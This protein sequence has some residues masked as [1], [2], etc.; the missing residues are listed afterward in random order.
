MKKKN[1]GAHVNNES[2]TSTHF[3][4]QHFFLFSFGNAGF[5][6]DSKVPLSM[7]N[8]KVF[9]FLSFFFFQSYN[10]SWKLV[11]C[12]CDGPERINRRGN[13]LPLLSLRF[14]DNYRWTF[15]SLLEIPTSSTFPP[16][17]LARPGASSRWSHFAVISRFRPRDQ[18]P[19]TV[20]S[21]ESRLS[22]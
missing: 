18:L 16:S 11:A 1:L 5:E 13:E 3:T 7:R 21:T 15:D 14:V 6:L 22:Q 20:S 10:W 4:R 8:E 19:S 17:M 12:C 9:V 2:R